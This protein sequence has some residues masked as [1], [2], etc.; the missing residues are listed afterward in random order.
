MAMVGVRPIP[1]RPAGLTPIP[2]EAL[3]DALL[4]IDRSP[5]APEF[6]AA[7]RGTDAAESLRLR[8]AGQ[9]ILLV[10]DN[11]V[12]QEVAAELLES[13]GLVVEAVDNG[14][15]AVERV[16]S[17]DYAL[18]LM[19]LQMPVMDGLT[20]TRAIR[21]RIGPATP[22][23]AM[24][25]NAFAEDRAACLAAGMDD[26]IAKPVNPLLLFAT[27]LRWLPRR[28]GAEPV[29]AGATDVDPAVPRDQSLQQRLAL[30]PGFDLAAALHNVGDRLPLLVRVLNRFVATYRHGEPALTRVDATD[31]VMVWAAACHSLRGA[32][33]TAGASLLPPLL[34]T[35][36]SE[37]QHGADVGVLAERALQVQ[38]QLLS[39]VAAL[40]HEL[41]D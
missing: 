33:A 10:E 11:P 13:V 14:A 27:L 21:T 20:A 35:F 12:N 6:D 15:K 36:E 39:L 5:H 38:S 18:I 32:C 40:E 23:V 37:L 24:T 4:P 25:A 30:V 34:Q 31:P 29:P 19:D 26:H 3:Y 1:G 16:G 17:R 8:H 9:P 28:A 7:S 2:S 22:I 41:A